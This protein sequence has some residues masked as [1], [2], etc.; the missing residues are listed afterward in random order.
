MDLYVVLLIFTTLA[1][2]WVALLLDGTNSQFRRNLYL[3]LSLVLNLGILFYF[4]YFNFLL[5]SISDLGRVLGV[6][7]TPAYHSLILPIGISFYTFQEIAY[8]IDVYRRRIP[9]EHHFGIYTTFVVFFPQLV[10]GP[11]ERA[12]EILPQFRLVFRWD[13]IRVIEGLQLILWGFFKK[14]VVA[15]RLAAYVNVVYSQPQ[16][17]TSL[18]ILI[19]TI[20]FAF[21][22]YCDFSGYTDIAIGLAKIMGFTLMQNFRQ[23]YF[24]KSVREFWSR[25][26]ISLSTWFR[27]YLYIPLGGNRVAFSRNL[28]NLFIVFAVSGIWHGANWTFLIW[29]AVHGS[30]VVI[31]TIVAHRKTATLRLR[32]PRIFGVL[33]TFSIVTFAWVFFRAN[34]AADAWYIVQKILDFQSYRLEGIFLYPAQ[35]P[36]INLI[37]G[38]FDVKLTGH[39]GSLVALVLA[40]VLIVVLLFYDH[41]E[42]R[43][44]VVNVLKRTP[45]VIRWLYYWGMAASIILLGYWGLQSFIYFQF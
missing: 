33:L 43:W 30:V 19:A 11:I 32:W 16:E 4:K 41:L 45:L 7:H 31:E 25:W 37:L 21:Q 20:F 3:F 28:L 17:H 44:G 18:A 40:W 24:A 23:P 8:V 22:I 5:N 36:G 2:F 35:D 6:D 29:G 14:V 39:Q 1:D 34:S 42:A 15:D 26:H 10:A 12:T 9:A 38:V 27:D 13:A